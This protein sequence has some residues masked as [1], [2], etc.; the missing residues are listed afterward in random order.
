MRAPTR[1]AATGPV[2][3]EEV[4]S[5]YLREQPIGRQVLIE[6]VRDAR[7]PEA[8]G[9]AELHARLVEA[10]PHT[11]AQL[12]G[13]RRCAYCTAQYA[14]RDNVGQWKCRFHPGREEHDKRVL[15]CVP[16]FR[17]TCCDQMDDAPGC[18]ACDHAEARSWS[19]S[20]WRGGTG[21]PVPSKTLVDVPEFM[22]ATGMLAPPIP[23]ARLQR[24]DRSWRVAEIRHSQDVRDAAQEEQYQA[25]VLGANPLRVMRTDHYRRKPLELY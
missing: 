24:A 21:A 23:E 14:E 4:M 2:H 7:M 17:W 1:V 6:R 22:L 18:T 3:A 8:R 20:E 12:L 25:W 11:A 9:L 15:S 13:P 16:R 19:L 10:H 5:H